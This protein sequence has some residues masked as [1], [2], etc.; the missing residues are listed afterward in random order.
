MD[1]S[2]ALRSL[3]VGSNVRRQG[4]PHGHFLSLVAEGLASLPDDCLGSFLVLHT[5]EHAP[6]PWTPTQGDL[7]ACDWWVTP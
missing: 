6:V 7:L 5:D 2:E 4:W 1:F 3:Q